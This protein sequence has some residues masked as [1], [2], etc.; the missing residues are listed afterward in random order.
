MNEQCNQDNYRD[1]SVPVC[2]YTAYPRT[3][4]LALCGTTL[5]HHNGQ[6]VLHH[7]HAIVDFVRFVS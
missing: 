1:D 4:I 2:V 5:S 6:W 7:F 3:T